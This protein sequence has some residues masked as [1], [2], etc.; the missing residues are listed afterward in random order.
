MKVKLDERQIVKTIKQR[1]IKSLYEWKLTLPLQN[2]ELQGKL[3]I[4]Y[5]ETIKIKHKMSFYG[6]GRNKTKCFDF[7]SRRFISK[8]CYLKS[9]LIFRFGFLFRM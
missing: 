2:G 7:N 8:H 3:A 1:S 9:L 6:Q 5:S 4:L